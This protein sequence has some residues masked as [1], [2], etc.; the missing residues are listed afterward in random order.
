LSACRSNFSQSGIPPGFVALQAAAWATRP[1]EKS[2]DSGNSGIGNLNCAANSAMLP[3]MSSVHEIE[4][5]LAKL[6][7]D[8]KQAVRDRLDDLIEDQLEVS[9]EFKTKVQRAKQ[10]F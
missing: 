1:E 5:A 4:S 3:V 2:R 7:L 10:E 6:T 9:D 8:E